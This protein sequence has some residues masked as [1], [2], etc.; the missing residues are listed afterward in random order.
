[1]LSR[2][3]R[4]INVF[5]VIS[6]IAALL[7]VI[8]ML[9]ILLEVLSPPSAAWVHIRENLLNA[10]IRN[11]LLLIGFVAVFSALLGLFSA[12]VVSR[13]EF[14][15]RNL[16]SWMLILPLAMP[17]YIAAYI[18]A[19]MFSYTGTIAR[20]MRSANIPLRV[21]MMNL[22]GAIFI[23]T[24]TLFPYVYMMSRSALSSQ[25]ASFSENAR[26]LGANR[27]R[28]LSRVVLPL[29][30]PALVAGTLLVV[31]E[32]LNDYGVVA[33]YNV[34]VF[35]FAIFN[36]WFSLGDTTAAIR[37]SGVLM[38]IVFAIIFIERAI[39]GKRQY[40]M[41]VKGKPVEP[42]KLRGISAFIVPATL[43]L[44]MALAFFIPLAQ[45]F[46]YASLTFSDVINANFIFLIINSLTLAITATAITVFVA[47]MLAN[48]NRGTKNRFKKGLLKVTNLGYAIPGAVIAIAV[49]LFVHGIDRTL[50]PVYRLFNP[51]TGRLVISST[52]IM[53]TFAFVLRFMA[54][55]YNSIEAS[56]DKVGEKFTEASYSLRAGKLRTLLTVDVP[57]IKHGLISAAIIVF[58]DVIKELPLTLILRPTNYNTLASEVFRYAREEM[59]QESA[60]PALVLIGVATFAIYYL[61]HYNKKGVA[62]NVREN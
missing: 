51:D 43:W 30:R 4:N 19:D 53:L 57:M 29:L 16:L 45:L 32:T 36:A 62:A 7:I 1:M 58:I 5:S 24:M 61:T 14:R 2:I 39:R 10:Y 31:L 55:G 17:S 28:V 50:Y 54:I 35:S 59:L 22:S 33:Y 20:F 44:I 21:N 56:Y 18:Y 38:L 12:Y 8:P 42:K 3:K 49:M 46:Y 13:F 15:G 26:L 37:L 9:N 23:F 25:S 52:L 11:T 60:V 40:S 6:V 27:F 41:H 48:Y 34:R 47:L